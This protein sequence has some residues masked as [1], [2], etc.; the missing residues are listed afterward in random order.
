MW[1]KLRKRDRLC[2]PLSR[3]LIARQWRLFPAAR[4]AA[5]S[6]RSGGGTLGRA[7]RILDFQTG[8]DRI[9]L[10]SDVFRKLDRGA[11][12]SKVFATGSPD[13]GNDYLVF[14]KGKLSYDKDGDGDGGMK[15]IAKLADHAKLHADDI[16][17]G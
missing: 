2:W 12:K 10:D 11:L 3:A 7:D 4:A 16:L 15:L 5:A 17:I 13:D 14:G 9:V 6:R 8:P 1:A